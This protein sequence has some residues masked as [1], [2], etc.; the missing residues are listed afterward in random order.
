MSQPTFSLPD[1]LLCD[2]FILSSLGCHVEQS[3]CTPYTKQGAVY[4][5]SGNYFII[6]I[7][8]VGNDC[9]LDAMNSYLRFNLNLANSISDVNITPFRCTDSI[10]RRLNKVATYLNKL[11]N[12]DYYRIL[13]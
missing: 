7:Q 12:M 11:M 1:Q 2:K 6:N 5:Q 4:V 13:C 3:V 8:K 9:C 10:F